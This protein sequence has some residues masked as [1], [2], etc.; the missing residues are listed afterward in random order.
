MQQD[1]NFD[2]AEVLLQITIVLGSV[3][4]CPLGGATSAPVR[5]LALGVGAVAS[6]LLVN[7]FLR[8]LRRSKVPGPRSKESVPRDPGL[9]TS[10]AGPWTSTSP[11][12]S[13]P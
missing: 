4:G 12:S 8:S 5:C 13:T 11:G 1:P 2:Y 9:W 10:D 6:V 3:V 7:G